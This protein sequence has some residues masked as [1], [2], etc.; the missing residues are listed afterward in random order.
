M[1]FQLVTN[2]QDCKVWIYFFVPW[3]W[4]CLAFEGRGQLSEVRTGSR[5]GAILV[6]STIARHTG[7]LL[8]D[9]EICPQSTGSRGCRQRLCLSFN[10]ILLLLV[11]Q[12]EGGRRGR[13]PYPIWNCSGHYETQKQTTWNDLVRF[14]KIRNMAFGAGVRDIILLF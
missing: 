6:P 7:R 5:A 12:W 2:A 11:W 13:N 1:C 9:D 14:L 3:H 4:L 8:I 10:N